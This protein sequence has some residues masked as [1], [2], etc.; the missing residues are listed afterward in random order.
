MLQYLLDI[1]QEIIKNR[2]E[3]VDEDQTRL[4]AVI[5][6]Q[7]TWRGHRTRS[8]LKDILCLH[9]PQSSCTSTKSQVISR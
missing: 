6:I 3:S 5:E 9:K 4:A 7:R 8:K 1:L 2:E